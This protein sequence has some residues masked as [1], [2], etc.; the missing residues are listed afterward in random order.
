MTRHQLENLDQGQKTTRVSFEIV[1][2]VSLFATLESRFEDKTAV[3]P[4]HHP[5]EGLPEADLFGLV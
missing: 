1:E 4:P 3:L 2:A 5:Y